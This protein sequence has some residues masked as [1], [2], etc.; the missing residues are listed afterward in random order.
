MKFKIFIRTL[1]ACLAVM[2]ALL[3]FAVFSIVSYADGSGTGSAD[4]AVVL[5]QRSGEKGLPCSRADQPR[6]YTIPRGPC[7]EDYLHRCARQQE[8][9]ESLAAKGYAINAGVPD[10]IIIEEKSRTTE[11]NLKYALA[12]SREHDSKHCSS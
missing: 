12:L 11:E 7:Q 8:R 9:V 2:I 6:H 10:R 3:S 1:L 5:G 4:A